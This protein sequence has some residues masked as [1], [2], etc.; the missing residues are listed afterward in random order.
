MN[1]RPPRFPTQL[2]KGFRSVCQELSGSTPS[3][4]PITSWSSRKAATYSQ[5]QPRSLV[6]SVSQNLYQR[7]RDPASDDR[8]EGKLQCAGARHG[9]RTP[10]PEP[11]LSVQ[12]EIAVAATSVRTKPLDLLCWVSSASPLSSEEEAVTSTTP[13]IWPTPS[14]SPRPTTAPDGPTAAL[15]RPADRRH[16]ASMKGRPR[17]DGDWVAIVAIPTWAVAEVDEPRDG[18]NRS[19]GG[20]IGPSPPWPRG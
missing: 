5:P 10:R 8:A 18:Q 17:R 4:E 13:R 3:K 14:R 12:T 11:E 15:R 19:C 2:T 6:P 20:P 1:G 7:P 16:V 9:P